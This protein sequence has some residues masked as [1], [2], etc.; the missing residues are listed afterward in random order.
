MEYHGRMDTVELGEQIRAVAGR[1]SRRLR[2]ESTVGDYTQSQKN[3]VVRLD[4]E[5][6]STLSALARA[7]G[8]KPQSMAT[9]LVALSKA[10]VV[11]SEPDPHDRRQTLWSLTPEARADL[12]KGR[13]ARTDWLVQEIRAALTREQE[14]E[15]ARGIQLLAAVIDRSAS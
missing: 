8:M 10:S 7:E 11:Q 5:G 14:A 4:R 13:A 6:A 1:L 15:L 3:V 9:I 2:E 12:A